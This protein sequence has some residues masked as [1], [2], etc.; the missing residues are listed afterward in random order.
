MKINTFTVLPDTPNE[1]AHLKELAYNLRFSWD[2]K[3]T[4]LFEKLDPELWDETSHSPVK[5][6]SLLHEEKLQQAANDE[7]FIEELSEVYEDLQ[8]Y[9]KRQSWYERTFGKSDK[10][11]LV[12]FCCEYGLHE[13]LPIYSGGLGVLAGDHMKSA[14][15]LGLPLVG[16][17]LF[18][19]EG[20]KR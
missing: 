16:I 13:S 2:Y 19:R 4:R 18:Y 8:D 7:K 14:S 20:Y 9:L 17:G 10:T 5:F 15:D 3:T 12:Y 11:R 1:L 6:L